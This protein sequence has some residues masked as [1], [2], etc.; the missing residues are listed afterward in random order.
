MV[1]ANCASNSP[2]IGAH[3]F[4]YLLSEDAGKSVTV[5]IT[6][7]CG[8]CEQFELEFSPA[9]FEQLADQSVGL[10]SGMTWSFI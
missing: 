4:T 2:L 7:R 1:T 10:I 8:D 3:V 9:A 5:T 6:D